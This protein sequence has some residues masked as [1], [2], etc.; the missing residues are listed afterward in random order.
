Q[1]HVLAVPVVVVDRDVAGVAAE[2]PARRVRERVPDR[3]AAPVRGGTAFHLVRRGRRPEQ[4]ILRETR[5]GDVRDA[6]E[7]MG[8]GV[9][10]CHDFTAPS[11]IPPMIW[12]PNTTN[13]TSNGTVD[14]AVAANTCA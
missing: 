4:E 9:R 8:D 3:P 11:M 7:A 14:S 2:P 1:R 12:R 5:D 6:G 13:T 10:V